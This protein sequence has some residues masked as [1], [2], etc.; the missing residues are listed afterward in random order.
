MEH[1]FEC[2]KCSKVFRTKQSLDK[3][4]SE[5][6]ANRYKFCPICELLVLKK[7]LA[8]HLYTH[9]NLKIYECQKC[10]MTYKTKY[11]L[12]RHNNIVHSGKNNICC[13]CGKAFTRKERLL[14]HIQN[15]HQLSN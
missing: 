15:F 10:S 6:H 8:R 5:N 7:N 12:D 2:L 3:H 1:N 4:F 11:H 13:V 14:T 9:E